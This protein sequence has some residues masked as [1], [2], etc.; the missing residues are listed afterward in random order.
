MTRFPDFSFTKKDGITMS[1]QGTA[2][3]KPPKKSRVL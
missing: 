2:A 1:T 3:S